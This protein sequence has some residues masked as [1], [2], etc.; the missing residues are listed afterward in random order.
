MLAQYLV[1]LLIA[2][3]VQDLENPAP[4]QTEPFGKGDSVVASSE[5]V[6]DLAVSYGISRH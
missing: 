5:Q 1:D 3:L 4:V 2:L 6:G